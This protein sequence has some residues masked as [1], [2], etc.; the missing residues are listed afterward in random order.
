MGVEK[1]QWSIYTT[2]KYQETRMGLKEKA[3]LLIPS[4]LF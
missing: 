1:F 4:G 2:I 3:F